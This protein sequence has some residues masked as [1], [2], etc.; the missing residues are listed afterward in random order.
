MKPSN[1][2][3]LLIKSLNKAEKTYF[4]KFASI[5]VIGEVNNYVRLF[6]FIGGMKSYDEKKIFEK[7][8]NEKFTRQ[9]SV[10]KNYLYEQILWSL[11]SYRQ[12]PTKREEVR[13]TIEDIRILYEKRLF[14][15]VKKKLRWCRKISVK[16]ELYT[17]MIQILIWELRIVITEWAY[18]KKYDDFI[19]ENYN[20]RKEIL[21]ILDN[22]FELDKIE[23]NI[24]SYI[25]QHSGKKDKKFFV[26]LNEIM[27]SPVL[28]SESNVL[29]TTAKLKYHHIYSTYFYATDDLENC[30]RSLEK[31]VSIIT[32][33]KEIV[34]DRILD[35]YIL[36]TNMLYISLEL[37][38]FGEFEKKLQNL[39][40]EIH[41]KEAR[42]NEIVKYYILSRSYLLE[43][44][45]LNKS[46]NHEKVIQ[47]F[48]QTNQNLPWLFDKLSKTE[49]FTLYTKISQSYF[50]LKN[51][52]EALN[53]LNKILNDPEAEH[54]Y[55][56]ISQAK[57]YCLIIHYELRNFDLLEY[58]I[59]STYRYILKKK[60]NYRFETLLFR[61]LRKLPDVITDKELKEIFAELKFNLE[62]ISKEEP[63]KTALKYFD[64][65]GWL[66]KKISSRL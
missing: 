1:D 60:H 10:A 8:G 46:G 33:R 53:Y 55:S 36:I 17:E 29:S 35:Y 61:F 27:N 39:K 40:D 19:N 23:F 65:I 47:L 42:R 62:K 21:R 24:S 14:L 59:V 11:K 2:L 64:F 34:D 3:F 54:R 57:I 7:F 44:S 26:G 22:M 20:Q 41:S 9:I 48:T 12:I 31:E 28:K 6:D 13:E 5:H 16:Y 50:S 38:K 52:N 58:L 51:F 66:D 25:N 15:Q 56:E 45:Y 49:Q 4:K 37:S 43:M 32:E 30:Y 18:E 63:D